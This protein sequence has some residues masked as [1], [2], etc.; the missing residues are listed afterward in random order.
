MFKANLLATAGW[1]CL[2]NLISNVHRM[3]WCRFLYPF[4]LL[5][6]CPQITKLCHFTYS[7]NKDILLRNL[8]K[9]YN[10]VAWAPVASCMTYGDFCVVY[11]FHKWE[12][13]LP[14]RLV[15]LKDSS[16]FRIDIFIGCHA[17]R[18]NRRGIQTSAIVQCSNQLLSRTS[19]EFLVK[20][21]CMPRIFHSA[22][23]NPFL[24]E[25]ALT[26]E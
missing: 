4:H 7:T 10:I 26:R 13:K 18:T 3:D 11:T 5:S 14:T 15:P 9:L 1:L 23:E 6:F 21:Q 8:K 22:M 2:R 24:V 25:Q 19:P 17:S 20:Q 12:E 16:I